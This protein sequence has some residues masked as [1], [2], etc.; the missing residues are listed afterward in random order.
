MRR[1]G[2]GWSKPAGGENRAARLAA[3]DAKTPPR[4]SDR[5]RPR[6][7]FRPEQNWLNDPNGL[8]QW[9][10][11]YHL[12][13]QHNPA[14][15]CHARIHWGHAVSRDLVHWDHQP[16][17][18]APTPGGSGWLAGL[19]GDSLELEAVLEAGPE[20]EFGLRLLASPGGEEQTRLVYDSAEQRLRLEAADSSLSPTVDRGLRQAPLK[21]DAGHELRLRVFVDGSIIEACA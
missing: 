4:L 5:W 13:Y 3:A 16:V 8:I 2:I 19:R 20:A 17:A 10:G 21:L 15:P 7:H 18:L 12:F 6:F 9:R 14:G 1:I 11:E